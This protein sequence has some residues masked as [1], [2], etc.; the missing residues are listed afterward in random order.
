M[1]KIRDALFAVHGKIKN[2]NFILLKRKLITYFVMLT[3]F[4]LAVMSFIYLNYNVELSRIKVVDSSLYRLQSNI[5]ELRSLQKEMN[6]REGILEKL[7]NEFKKDSINYFKKDNIISFTPGYLKYDTFIGLIAA[8]EKTG[9]LKILNL[10][11]TNLNGNEKNIIEPNKYI[12]LKKLVI[13]SNAKVK[14]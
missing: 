5:N 9:F 13:Y 7:L 4:A 14:K 12:Y 1:E 10:E 2:I 6:E 8:I 11:I 3:L